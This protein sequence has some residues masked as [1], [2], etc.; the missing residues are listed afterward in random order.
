MF[1]LPFFDFHVLHTEYS[2]ELS[3]KLW[4]NARSI[5]LK[6][7]FFEELLRGLELPALVSLPTRPSRIKTQ[8][9]EI[10][11]LHNNSPRLFASDICS[12]RLLS[13]SLAFR[14]LMYTVRRMTGLRAT[15]L[16]SCHIAQT[17]VRSGANNWSLWSCRQVCKGSCRG[18]SV[19]HVTIHCQDKGDCALGSVSNIIFWRDEI[20]TSPCYDFQSRHSTW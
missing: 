3:E 17:R 12:S 20:K 8:T 11:T 9:P 6:S 1:S 7:L 5:Y 18:C 19:A 15:Q 10:F 14:A 16:R 13:P 4:R 2:T